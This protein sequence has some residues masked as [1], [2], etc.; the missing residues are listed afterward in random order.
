MCYR[1]DAKRVREP[2]NV[3]DI[4]SAPRFRIQR[5]WYIAVSATVIVASLTGCGLAQEPRFEVASIRRSNPSDPEMFTDHLPG[6]RYIAKNITARRLIQNAYR[7]LDFQIADGPRWIDS[8]K[9][10]IDAKGNEDQSQGGQARFDLF[11]SW[12]RSLLAERFA[13]KAHY[14]SK[15]E[16]IYSLVPINGKV[17]AERVTNPPDTSPMTM[18][19]GQLDADAISMELL[20]RNLANIVGRI[21]Q[22]RTNLPG[23]YKFRLEWAL[24]D[25]ATRSD[26]PSI[27][28]A[29]QEQLGLKLEPGKGQV[30]TLIIDH[31][32]LPSEN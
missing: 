12:L 26:R 3:S 5:R 15:E 24:E 30:T 31:I 17:K 28:T 10:N 2:D 32:A 23:K 21:V 29:L 11:R 4:G 14:G 19:R 13:L 9:F 16:R 1:R 22:D 7:L 6:G 20:A 18:S 8:V 25:Q 27:F